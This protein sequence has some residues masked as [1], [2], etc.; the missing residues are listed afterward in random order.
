[1]SRKPSTSLPRYSRFNPKHANCLLNSSLNEIG[2]PIKMYSK[3]TYSFPTLF[4]TMVNQ[5]FSFSTKVAS[6]MSFPTKFHPLPK[7]LHLFSNLELQFGILK[8]P[9]NNQPLKAVF[10]H[11]LLLKSTINQLVSTFS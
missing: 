9:L 10:S 1:M 8:S 7:K 4:L 11:D 3:T 2:S 5:N 6:T